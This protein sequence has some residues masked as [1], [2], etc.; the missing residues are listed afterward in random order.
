MRGG[1]FT[2]H[3]VEV[4]V[5]SGA[6]EGCKGSCRGWVIVRSWGIES[7]RRGDEG[8]CVDGVGV[9]VKEVCEGFVGWVAR[10]GTEEVT[11]WEVRVGRRR[12]VLARGFVGKFSKA[13][14]ADFDVVGDIPETKLVG[15]GAGCGRV[16]S[17][18]YRWQE[19]RPR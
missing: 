10:A 15:I 12:R 2:E 5:K 18:V 6:A 7:E 9:A 19:P 16:G 14:V 11:T 13:L 1:H 4:R 17:R 3:R 8:W